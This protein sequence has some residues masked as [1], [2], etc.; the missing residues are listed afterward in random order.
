VSTQ[1][2]AT[3]AT[4]TYTFDPTPVKGYHVTTTATCRRC[5]SNRYLTVKDMTLPAT[6]HLALNQMTDRQVQDLQAQ[7][8]AELALTAN[9]TIAARK[10]GRKRQWFINLRNQDPV[11]AE[12]WEEAMEEAADD[13]EYLAQQR[14]F[15]GVEKPV[16]YKGKQC[17]E[18]TEYSDSMAMF[19]LRAHRPE[20]FRERS[21]VKQ[22][23]T[24]AD[25]GPLRVANATELTDD[26]L[27]RLALGDALGGKPREITHR[28]REH[29]AHEPATDATEVEPLDTRTPHPEDDDQL[30]LP[31]DSPSE[32]LDDLV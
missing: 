12:R 23:L 24:G 10:L 26:Q 14:A 19:L 30:S 5:N 32:S 17:G 29:L 20:R 8:I 18:V 27:A 1:Q 22:Q 21:D 6:G 16:F 13:L 3:L 15:L 9:P 11:F 25:G 4:R 2:R 7:F 28:I 31:F